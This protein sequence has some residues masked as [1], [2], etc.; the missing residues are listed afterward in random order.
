MRKA[1]ATE[2]VMT[3]VDLNPER[4][5]AARMEAQAQDFLKMEPEVNDIV[6]LARI[7][8]EIIGGLPHDRSSA[9]VYF[10]VAELADRIDQ[11]HAKYYCPA[12]NEF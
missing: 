10:V 8:K 12:G 11:M 6:Q 7:G 9:M 2:E 4:A 1:S 3:V 5:R